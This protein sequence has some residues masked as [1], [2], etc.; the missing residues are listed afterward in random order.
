MEKT[1][2]QTQ[3]LQGHWLK[4]AGQ[5]RAEWDIKPSGTELFF[6]PAVEA[7]NIITIPA[8][9]SDSEPKLCQPRKCSPRLHYKTGCLYISLSLLFPA[10][11]G[12]T[13]GP[14]LKS[15]HFCLANKDHQ[16]HTNT[17]VQ[18]V[19]P[20]L[21]GLWLPKVKISLGTRSVLHYPTPC[22]FSLGPLLL[23]CWHTS[24]SV[25]H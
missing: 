25:E 7:I 3:Q 5:W 11:W 6:C 19:V 22:L 20:R 1:G 12:V 10:P 23:F 8:L 9:M 14:D 21:E 17:P 15:H 13:W 24:S 4:L 18:H 16:D 2:K